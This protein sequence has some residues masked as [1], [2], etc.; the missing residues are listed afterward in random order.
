MAPIDYR[1]DVQ[2]PVLE[3]M[4]GFNLAQT[5][6]LQRNEI[7]RQQQAQQRQAQI[8]E[9]LGA[10]A[11]RR[12]KTIE[13]YRNLA[14]RFP[15]LSEQ[16]QQTLS[17]LSEEQ[18]Q[19]RINRVMPIYAALKSGNKEIAGDLVDEQISAS[20]YSQDPMESKNFELIK[21]NMELD[22]R[23]ALTA[24]RIYLYSAMGEDKFA[25]M[26]EQLFDA[27]K[28]PEGADNIRMSE[29]LPDKT[30]VGVTQAGEII[31]KDV[32]GRQLFGDEAKRKIEEAQ[33]KG[34]DLRAEAAK[35][36]AEARQ[37]V[38]Q[39]KIYSGQIDSVN[40]DI[41]TLEEARNILDTA[42]EEDKFVGVGPIAQYLPAITSTSQE[43][44]NVARR[45]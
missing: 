35:A 42:M 29:F 4:K 26:D 10:F 30:M 31:V 41:G 12:G 24:A 2:N 27:E 7:Q 6:A 36:E 20:K 9:A 18:R 45:R 19:G 3:A 33:Q 11:Q 37:S 13:D 22:P 14:I 23:G 40:S 21:R 16:V 1:I 17:N 25:K 39:V 34:I 8:Q 15:E 5:M 38:E 28:R 32:S 44:R 43:M